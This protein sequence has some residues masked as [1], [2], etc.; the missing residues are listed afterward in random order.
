[1]RHGNLS[2][3]DFSLSSMSADSSHRANK[4]SL[5]RTSTNQGAPQSS[6]GGGGPNNLER[7]FGKN[8]FVDGE[9]LLRHI[10]PSQ[11]T[12]SPRDSTHAGGP[13]TELNN[14][15]Q[16]A[17]NN[18]NVNLTNVAGIVAEPASC[19]EAPSHLR[20]TSQHSGKRSKTTRGGQRP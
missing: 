16:H 6:V 19:K 20:L 7:I 4:S 1:M 13:T 11:P 3:D 17:S 2:G 9:Q 12:R 18:N 10:S 8:Y 5:N 15:M 14:Q